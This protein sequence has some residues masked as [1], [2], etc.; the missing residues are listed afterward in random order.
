MSAAK[1]YGVKSESGH[2]KRNLILGI[3]IVVLIAGVIAYANWPRSNDEVALQVGDRAF[4]VDEVNYFYTQAYQQE[5]QM[6]Q[7]YVQLGMEGGMD[8]NTPA[9]E[10]VYDEASGQTYADFFRET[11]VNDLQQ[12]A[13]LL[14]QAKQAG[15]TLSDEGKA[16]VAQQMKGLE[17]SILQAQVTQG[18]SEAYY[19]KYMYG[20]GMTKAKVKALITDQTLA[21]EYADLRAEAFTYDDAALDTYYQANRDNLDSY[22]YRAFSIAATPETDGS[23][24]E[25]GNPIPATEAQTEAA[26]TIARNSANEMA[27]KI[28]GGTD[29][30][31]VAAEYAPEADKTKYQEGDAALT[32]DSQGSALSSSYASWLKDAARRANDITVLDNGTSGCYVVQFVAREKR[33]SSVETLDVRSLLVTA[34]T[35]ETTA[36]DG[37]VTK[38]ANDEQLAAAQAKAHALRD[39]F[40]AASEKTPEAFLALAPA[41]DKS[42]SADTQEELARSSYGADFDKQAFTPDAV[43]AGDVLLTEATDSTG[44]AIGY[45]LT[46]VNA[47]GQARWSYAAESTLRSEAYTNWFEEFKP[48][49]EPAPT[50]ALQKVG[51]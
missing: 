42:I 47:L 1:Q 25:E 21:Q 35:T 5:A 14:D 41:S 11:A 23:L 8:T 28:R 12:L 38:A 16:E 40:D 36:E 45:R 22:D 19:I 17:D 32:V 27:G 3:L 44:A 30:S 33:E 43:R 49:Y 20:E 15:H 48:Q 7:F 13:I 9:S 29:F 46:Y 51:S 34:E 50:D 10:Q 18:G 37:T 24:D 26:M 39:S 31:Q 6:A 2:S 4:N